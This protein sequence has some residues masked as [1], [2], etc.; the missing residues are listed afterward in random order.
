MTA[1]RFDEKIR[2]I[3][4]HL[5]LLSWVRR[6]KMTMEYN[7]GNEKTA[8]GIITELIDELYQLRFEI[9]DGEVHFNQVRRDNNER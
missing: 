4:R 2:N 5:D 6:T 3:K 9:M 8:V 1:K 7:E